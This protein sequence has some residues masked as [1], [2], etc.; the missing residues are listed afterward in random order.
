[1][2]PRDHIPQEEFFPFVEM[3]KLV[4]ENHILRLIDRYVDFGFIHELVDPTYS[5]VT[6]R[7]AVDP[8]LMIRILVIGYLNN[9]SER[10]LFEEL[11][12]HAAYRWFCNLGF[13]DPTPDRSTLNKLRN[14]RWTRDGI[15]ERIMQNIVL[16]CVKA[17]LVKG[18]HVT[19]DG[20][21]IEA[22]ASIKSLEPVVIEVALDDYLGN[23]KLKR[24]ERPAH[25]DTTHPQDKDFHG[26]KLSN[27]T[28]R[29]TTDPDARLF[30]KAKGQEASLSYIGNV[31]IDTKSRVIL[32][33]AVTQPGITT[34]SD[35][36]LAMLDALPETHQVT[37]IAADTGYGNTEFVTEMFARG[38]A[39]HVPLLAKSDYE[40]APS[41]KTAAHS[42]ERKEKRVK[43]IKQ[44]AARNR[45]R[46]INASAR[47]KQSQKH[48]KRIE[49]VFAEAKNCHGLDRA[50]G[51]RRPAMCQQLTMTGVVQNCKRLARFSFRMDIKAAEALLPKQN[52][53]SNTLS[54]LSCLLVRL[55]HHFKSLFDPLFCQF[56][57]EIP[58]EG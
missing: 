13:Y 20:T 58:F 47:Y 28:H 22:N 9:L 14:H 18:G 7:P 15:F 24:S 49:H 32:A 57:T 8:E 41:W 21:K 3:E 10:K 46:D 33:T 2:K 43:K 54:A 5:E 55:I 1:M 52:I 27:S 37:T 51:R 38:I 6:G 12:M 31:L 17:G 30:K 42:L 48:R 50:R 16:Q 19:V 56:S 35:A 53:L 4:P 40:P 29:S 25:D 34:E 45:V 11:R 23:L 36:A 39:P 26:E 44:V